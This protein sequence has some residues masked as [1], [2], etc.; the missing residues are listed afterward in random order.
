MKIERKMNIHNRFDIEVKDSVTGEVKQ[1]AYAENIILDA[2]WTK[3]FGTTSAYFAY[4][5]LGT[6]TGTLAASRTA[7]FTHLA[8]LQLTGTP[9]VAASLGD[10]YM[11]CRRSVQ[12]LENQYI[13]QV[14]SEIGIA[15]TSGSSYLVT[16]ALLRDM[17]G[18][19]TTI[20]KTATDIITFYATV[21]I[22]MPI[23]A[24][25][26]FDFD[27]V[28]LC[29]WKDG[30][31]PYSPAYST[32]TRGYGFRNWVVDWLFGL[33][34][35]PS[36]DYFAVL[37]SK[38]HEPR[39]PRS[40]YHTTTD[41][42]F[43][44]RY[45]NAF[46]VQVTP[47]VTKTLAQKKIDIYA[48]L[49][50]ASLNSFDPLRSV[51]VS[52]YGYSGSM[53]GFPQGIILRFPNGDYAGTVVAGEA[54]G[55]GDGSTV[56]FST[57]AGCIKAGAK[58][59]VD[60]VEQTSGVTVDALKPA[61]NSVINHLKIIKHNFVETSSGSNWDLYSTLHKSGY[62]TERPEYTPDNVLIFEN[63]Y[64]AF[65][66]IST[67]GLYTGAKVYV[68]DDLVT[69]TLVITASS[70]NNAVSVP[71]EH[72]GKRYWKIDHSGQTGTN[73]G[74]YGDILYGIT[75]FTNI[76]FA[77]APSVGAIITADYTVDGVAKDANHVF[78]ITFSIVLGEYTP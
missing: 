57:D 38:A 71:S 21:Y 73:K 58:I 6:G 32:A 23:S 45:T 47:T 40:S 51:L 55:V 11:S 49:P 1:R 31:A 42:S 12:I 30:A 18:N 34:N 68:S 24:D 3:L 74:I 69:W 52:I 37:F 5:N 64:Y 8:S 53:K 19:V 9:T 44:N 29:T 70:D 50:A 25:V 77:T 43:A 65:K 59:Y 76:H 16:H 35:L 66:G 67:F 33:G 27:P 22:R 56:N 2:L 14:L 60:A 26:L 15:H 46:G 54:I 62:G 10:G 78:D 13:G 28:E 20:T 63:P 39:V 17:N 7:L 61:S 36:Y 41:P 4:L 75:D 48:R 72:Q